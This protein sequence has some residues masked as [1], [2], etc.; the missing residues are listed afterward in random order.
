MWLPQ[1][2][3]QAP[4]GLYQLPLMM[5][6]CLKRFQALC[7]PAWQSTIQNLKSKMVLLAAS[8]G[9]R[10]PRKLADKPLEGRWVSGECGRLAQVNNRARIDRIA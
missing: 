10:L 7:C 4:P 6:H 5:P 3:Q 8:G 2:Y 9:D 1:R